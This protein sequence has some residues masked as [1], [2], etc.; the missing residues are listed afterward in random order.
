MYVYVYVY[1]TLIIDLDIDFSKRVMT[2][3]AP[4]HVKNLPS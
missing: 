3:A 1:Y 2:G 4:G